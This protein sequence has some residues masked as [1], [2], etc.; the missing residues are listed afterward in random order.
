MANEQPVDLVREARRELRAFQV[1]HGDKI[2][3]WL[4][5]HIAECW[6]QA[7][8]K[9][10]HGSQLKYVIEEAKELIKE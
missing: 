10:P 8:Q 5:I 2:K 7:M 1:K 4:S 3:P 9:D 6:E